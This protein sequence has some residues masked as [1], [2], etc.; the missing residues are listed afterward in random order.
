MAD[1]T[2]KARARKTSPLSRCRDQ[3]PHSRVIPSLRGCLSTEAARQRRWISRERPQ[4]TPSNAGCAI[5]PKSKPRAK[6]QP[7]GAYPG[8]EAH[9]GRLPTLR[10]RRR[11]RVDAVARG[12][13]SGRAWSGGGNSIRS[14]RFGSMDGGLVASSGD[15]YTVTIRG[16]MLNSWLFAG[17]NPGDAGYDEALRRVASRK[18]D[19]GL[20]GWGRG[21][22]GVI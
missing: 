20:V 16:D 13:M 14:V 18:L 8:P 7:R 9:R 21:V 22:R 17:F 1:G 3:T 5:G 11:S 19:R 4:A 12:E 15:L 6:S 2:A 10:E